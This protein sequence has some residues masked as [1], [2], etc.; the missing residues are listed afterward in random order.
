[1]VVNKSELPYQLPDAQS[2]GFVDIF[3]G[4]LNGAT[5]GLFSILLIAFFFAV[6]FG[7]QLR[8]AAPPAKAFGY[9]AFS[10]WGISLM[11]LAAGELGQYGIG[12]TTI[13]MAAAIYINVRGGNS[14]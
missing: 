11:L 2:S 6:P 10:A 12:L 4:W 9:G 1:M 7:L 5:G 14:R 13:T 8:S 3:I